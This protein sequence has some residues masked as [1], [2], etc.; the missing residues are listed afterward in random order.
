MH[1]LGRAARRHRP[2][3][4]LRMP[5]L[6]VLLSSWWV[7]LLHVPTASNCVFTQTAAVYPMHRSSRLVYCS[8]TL[9][10]KCAIVRMGMN[11]NGGC[12]LAAVTG[13]LATIAVVLECFNSSWAC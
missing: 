10:R 3:L 5:L 12:I 9:L 13:T 6:H 1:L 8:C 4:T 11:T 2:I 7:M